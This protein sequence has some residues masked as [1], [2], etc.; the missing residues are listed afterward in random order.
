[1][2]DESF[3]HSGNPAKSPIWTIVNQKNVIGQIRVLAIF[4][5]K[6]YLHQNARFI[7]WRYLE[8]PLSPMFLNRF[9]LSSDSIVNIEIDKTI[10]GVKDILS[11]NFE[12]TRNNPQ[13]SY[14]EEN[15]YLTSKFAYHLTKNKLRIHFS[16]ELKREINY[17]FPVNYPKFIGQLNE[18]EGKTQIKGVIGFSN[19]TFIL[20]VL[21]LTFLMIPFIS[22]LV[23]PTGVKDGEYTI[24]FIIFGWIPFLTGL[25]RSR[26]KVFEM[27]AKIDLLFEQDE[28]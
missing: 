20:P 10:S 2:L 1:V 4:N 19:W 15:Q 28:S 9:F 27:R 26:N 13:Y 23:N 25:I 11:S 3:P 12:R 18:T 5:P 6:H 8:L 7:Q 24:F 22:W 14:P 16:K 21:V 17:F